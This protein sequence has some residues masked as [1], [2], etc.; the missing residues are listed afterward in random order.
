[1]TTHLNNTPDAQIGID[2]Y[3]KSK[4]LFIFDMDGTIFDNTDLHR[5]GNT[6]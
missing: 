2:N 1:M 5:M 6:S 3:E 4:N